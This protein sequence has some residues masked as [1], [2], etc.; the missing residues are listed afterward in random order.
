ML[1]HGYGLQSIYGHLQ[2]IDVKAGD[3]IKKGQ[4]M[5]I[6][7]GTGLALGVHVHFSMQVDGV[8]TNPCEW[9][10]EHWIH[11]LILSKVQQ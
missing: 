10:D 5:G 3:M 7:G 2:R 1:N 8:Q 4:A 6:A 11:D 9:W